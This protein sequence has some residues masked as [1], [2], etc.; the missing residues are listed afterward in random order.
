MKKIAV[1][2]ILLG[3]SLPILAQAQAIYTGRSEYLQQGRMLCEYE[4][5]GMTFTVVVSG[6][7]CPASTDI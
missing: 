4:Y 5:N 7:Y 3:F 1:I 2:A 6:Y